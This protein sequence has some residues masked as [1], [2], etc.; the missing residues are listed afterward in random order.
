MKAAKLNENHTDA[1]GQS[2]P[3]W[4]QYVPVK[5]Y[6]TVQD[7]GV[8]LRVGGPQVYNAIKR[9]TLKGVFIN[10]VKHVRHTAILDYLA[11]RSDAPVFDPTKLVITDIIPDKE[12]AKEAEAMLPEGAERTFDDDFL[13]A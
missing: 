10:N 13:D 6:Y 2:A 7:V 1:D 5:E 4:E 11:R 9:G 12:A 8:I 3:R